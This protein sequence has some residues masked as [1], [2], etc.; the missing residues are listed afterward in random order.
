MADKTDNAVS[1]FSLQHHEILR[2]TLNI[3]KSNVLFL[4]TIQAQEMR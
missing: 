3:L 2:I 4:L 1:F